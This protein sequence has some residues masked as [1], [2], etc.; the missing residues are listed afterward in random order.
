MPELLVAFIASLDGDGAAEGWPGRFR[1]DR[2][3]WLTSIVPLAWPGSEVPF[4]AEVASLGAS[5][6]RR[7]SE[8]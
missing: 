7:G 2:P 4:R 6:S 3:V 8:R 5:P 1:P